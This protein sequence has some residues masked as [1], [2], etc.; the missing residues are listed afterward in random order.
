MAENT[1]ID[2]A[3]LDF[4][5]EVT[6][7]ISEAILTEVF[8]NP[9]I[10]ELHTFVLG[11]VTGK[12]IPILGL[13][14]KVGRVSDGNC[15]PKVN[16]SQIPM[17]EKR[18][19]PAYIED[20]FLQCFKPLMDSFFVFSLKPGVDKSDLT[21]TDFM[22]FLEDRIGTAMIDAVWRFIWFG[23]KAAANYNDSPA[24]F[25]TNTTDPD[26]FNAIDGFWKQI[27]TVVAATG[28][29]QYTAIA[30]NSGATYVD[31]E[32][33]DTDT[34]NQVITK[35]MRKML[36]K[37]DTRLK[38]GAERPRFMMT[39]SVADQYINERLAATGVELAYTRTETGFDKLTV[40]GT[41]M[42][43]IDIWDR[44]IMEDENNGTKL[45]LPHR[46]VLTKKSNLLVG[47][48]SEKTLT[49]L[50]PYYDPREREM[51]VDFGY[52]LDAVYVEDYK[53]QF[54]Y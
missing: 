51:L 42:Y 25:L 33:D 16:P 20:R 17:S 38:G 47:T 52:M 29:A 18:W 3:D 44:I 6:R 22:M 31:Q 35:L 30:K 43:V 28:T 40:M 50:R 15:T 14:G 54:A 7:S 5:G 36:N 26:F 34:T 9:A 11:I 46:I 48:E 23:D 4:S 37:A 12:P 45:H 39:R 10:K 13:L 32:F 41:E 27:K 1:V 8:D 21:G 24:G 2:P 49:E 53:G 19:A